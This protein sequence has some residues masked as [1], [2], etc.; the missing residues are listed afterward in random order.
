MPSRRHS[1]PVNPLPARAQ[2]SNHWRRPRLA[3]FLFLSNT[4]FFS[5]PLAFAQAP[6]KIQLVQKTGFNNDAALAVSQNFTSDNAAGDLLVAFV[7]SVGT[8]GY[9][10]T[11]LLD[12][13][14]NTWVQAGR[15]AN[16]SSIWYVQNC[17]AGP[18]TVVMEKS[19]NVSRGFLAIAEYSGAAQTGIVLDQTNYG[20]AAISTVVQDEILLGYPDA[21]IVSVFNSSA[22]SVDWSGPSAGFVIEAGANASFVGWADNLTSIQGQNPFQITSSA[23]DGLGLKI[24]AFL[25]S[26]VAPP[27]PGYNFIRTCES[28]NK[29]LSPMPGSPSSCTFPGGN[30][31]DD[32][33][34]AVCNQ[35][36]P[37]TDQVMSVTDTSGN[38]YVELFS[39]Y[40]PFWR[41]FT[42]VYA[43]NGSIATNASNTVSCNFNS[44]GVADSVDALAIEYSGQASGD[45]FDASASDSTETANNLSY[46]ITP[47]FPGELLFSVNVANSGPNIWSGLGIETDREPSRGNSNNETRIADLLLAPPGE[48]AITVTRAT[49]GLSGFTLALKS[50]LSSGTPVLQSANLTATISPNPV[51]QLG[52]FTVSGSVPGVAGF[53]TP[54]GVFS[55]SADGA[56]PVYQAMAQIGTGP[57]LMTIPANLFRAGTSQ[58]G[59]SYSG[60]T[61]YATDEIMLPLTVTVPYTLS[62][63]PVTVTMPGAT[64]SNRATIT[65]TPMGGF[66][67]TVH[68]TCALSKASVP[69]GAVFA[70]TCTIPDSASVTGTSATSVVMTIVSTP[71]SSTAPSIRLVL[72]T[73]ATLA[74]TT[75]I[76]FLVVVLFTR[77]EIIRPGI[78]GLRFTIALFLVVSTCVL[79]GCAGSGSG[80][81][82]Q[83]SGTTMGTY[84]FVVS[85]AVTGSDG[86]S[87]FATTASVTATIQ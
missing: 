45:I 72:P 28:L 78:V 42:D 2:I 34:L 36:F 33:V 77:T 32:L 81:G 54:T 5:A 68:L 60:D 79:A 7:A 46:S 65:I 21:L 17:K 9:D 31:R 39:R 15:A 50:R 59:V 71:S 27:T 24:A 62:A 29:T 40:D 85:A 30:D 56:N 82:E 58:I 16:N 12:S 37:S 8:A 63:T 76:F 38:R 80:G 10:V 4:A 18:N 6:G 64:M 84:T 61:N 13:Q 73:Y 23:I 41:T 87:L 67:G 25:P 74:S 43:N 52:A 35:F 75:T 26:L 66:A 86:T 47:A 19:G 51:D 69:P 11:K 55:I 48:N 57:I 44:G 14:G 20:F 22:Q 70:P 1:S 3:L 53:P 83:H 49:A